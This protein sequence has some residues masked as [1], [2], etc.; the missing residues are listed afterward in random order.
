M[1]IS[2]R[3]IAAA[4]LAVGST[5]SASAYTEMSL[6]DFCSEPDCVD[7]LTPSGGVVMDTSGT[8]YGAAAGG[9][10][11]H[12]GIVYS[13]VPHGS[14]Y[15]F[16]VI[17]DLKDADGVEAPYGDLVLDRDGRLYGTVSD[18]YSQGRGAVYQLT[19]NGSGWTFAVLHRFNGADGATPL[20]GLTYS[21][22]VSGKRWDESSPL[23]G[24]TSAGGTNGKGLIYEL[25]R[26]DAAWTETVV[27]EFTSTADPNAV[28]EDPGGNLWGTTQKGGKHEYG[29]LYRIA[30]GSRSATVFHDF[31]D[32]RSCIDGAYPKGRLLMDESGNFYGTTSAGGLNCE[33]DRG[34]GAVFEFGSG[35][36]YSVLYNFCPTGTCTDGDQPA[37]GLIMDRSG[38]LFGTAF[39]TGGSKDALEGGNGLVFELTNSS[40]AWSQSVLY[41][42]CLKTNCTDGANPESELTMDSSGNFFGTTHGY[43]IGARGNVFELRR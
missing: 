39:W 30:S 20:S 13:L 5:Q 40:G 43:S 15:T 2:A 41:D 22:Q 8:L 3:S 6:H 7:G 21:G 1:L 32:A 16:S 9:G 42:F 12:R 11:V 35:G 33:A 19:R 17:Y 23:Y 38:H 28:L 34:C 10:K 37:A 27:H 18:E 36:K 29:T 14:E 24:T 25:V 4:I 26:K 31:C